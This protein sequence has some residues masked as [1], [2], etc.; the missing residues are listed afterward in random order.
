MLVGSR[1]PGGPERSPALAA[2]DA[3]A[4]ITW[5]QGLRRWGLLRSFAVPDDERAETGDSG[6]RLCLVLQVSCA[7]AARRLAARWER[8]GGY[9]VSVLALRDACAGGTTERRAS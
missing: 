4:L 7:E 8:L 3:A 5:H 6:P 9:R 1:P 2:H